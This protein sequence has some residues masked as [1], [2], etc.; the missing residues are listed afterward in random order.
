MHALFFF[1]LQCTSAADSMVLVAPPHA[2]HL[3]H[4]RLFAHTDS[5]QGCVMAQEAEDKL[6]QLHEGNAGLID[7]VAELKVQVIDDFCSSCLHALRYMA[8]CSFTQQQC[9]FL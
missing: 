4:G 9:V 5:Q 2:A 8:T 6:S 7:A 1:H 3:P